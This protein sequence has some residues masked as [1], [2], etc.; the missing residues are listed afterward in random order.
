MMF[1]MNDKKRFSQRMNKIKHWNRAETLKQLH[2]LCVNDISLT[3]IPPIYIYVT[4]SNNE[5]I[6]FLF[7][8]F[9]LKKGIFLVQ[10]FSDIIV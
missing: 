1:F 3:F 7:F 10:I 8:F 6:F 4:L 9:L 2:G 5:Y